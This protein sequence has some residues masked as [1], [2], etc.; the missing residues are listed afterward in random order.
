VTDVAEVGGSGADHPT[1]AGV[2]YRVFIAEIAEQCRFVLM[3]V[4]ELEQL[5]GRD[6]SLRRLSGRRFEE[7]SEV[8][9]FSPSGSRDAAE[10]DLISRL[11]ELQGL[12]LWEYLR[13]L[14][15]HV[16]AIVDHAARIERI[17]WPT[18]TDMGR[19]RLL[20][21]RGE[22][23][24]RRLGIADSSTLPASIRSLRDGW[25]HIDDRIEQH[26]AERRAATNAEED[27]SGSS[28]TG[29]RL[30]RDPVLTV[31]AQGESLELE[32]VIDEVRILLARCQLVMETFDEP[33]MA[34]FYK[35]QLES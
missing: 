24:R 35:M 32:P 1:E 26:L 21:Q 29:W 17:L 2:N 10:F 15:Y 31:E 27:D 23:V 14:R 22:E 13:R 18:T 7:Y 3:A 25:H 33:E 12:G 28:P 34:I 20:P 9:G 5:E 30:F 8:F 6:S 19:P 16:D 11:I 4:K